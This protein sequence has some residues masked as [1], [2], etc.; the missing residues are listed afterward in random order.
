MW[1]QSLKSFELDKFVCIHQ[2]FLLEDM[3]QD[4]A[5]MV[6]ASKEVIEN[7]ATLPKIQV[8]K[9]VTTV[10]PI[11]LVTD[12]TQRRLEI[13]LLED[14]DQDYAD[15]VAASKVLMLKP[16]NGATLPKIQV[17]EGVTT[18]M[19]ITLVTDKTQRRLEASKVGELVG[20]IGEK[21]SQEDVNQKLLRSLSLEWNTHVIAWR[22]KADLDTMRMDDLYNNLSTNGVI[23][24]TQPV[25]TANEVSTTI[26]QVNVA[27]FT[28][29]E[30][31]S[32]VVI[33]TFLA[34]QQN[35]P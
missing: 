28:N 9:G 5:D 15:M 6:A 30:N 25:N 21:L 13:F 11:T 23:N 17:L 16:E 19:P 14:M 31:L 32:D 4:S 20:A 1:Y 10:M 34:S 7:G 26:T 27:F 29:I 12:K 22:N 2:I 8:L 35:T 18:V 33:C 3:D 24:T